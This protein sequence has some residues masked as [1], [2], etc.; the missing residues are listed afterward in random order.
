MDASINLVRLF[1]IERGVTAFVTEDVVV[2]AICT[3]FLRDRHA[4]ALADVGFEHPLTKTVVDTCRPGQAVEVALDIGRALHIGRVA[5]SSRC[6][7]PVVIAMDVRVCMIKAHA[8]IQ[9]QLFAQG[10]L[11]E[12]IGT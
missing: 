4:E 6:Q 2:D 8:G 9:L 7:E 1:R 5:C 10:P 12:S 3:Q 11:V